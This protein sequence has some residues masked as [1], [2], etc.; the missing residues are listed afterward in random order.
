MS[1]QHA[2]LLVD[3]DVG[4]LESLVYGFREADWRSTACST[5]ETASLLAK[6]S[7]AEIVIVVSRDD[8]AKTQTLVQQLRG[9]GSKR[10]LPILVLGPEELRKTLKESSGADLLPLPVLVRDVLTASK[11][12]VEASVAASQA[13]GSPEIR[14]GAG[15]T[16]IASLLRTMSGLERSGQ[17]HVERNGRPA[18]V[19][20]HEGAVAAAQV[21]QLRGMPA[22]KRVLIWDQEA[23]LHLRPVPR[24]GQVC[25]SGR[26]FVDELDRYQRDL[27]YGLKDIGPLSSVYGC[28]EQRMRQ[29]TGQVPAEVTPVVRLCDGQRSLSDI[30]DESLFPV[31]DTVRILSR[32]AELGI[33]V[34]RAFAE[35]AAPTSAQEQLEAFWQ[36]ARI[37][38]ADSA[39]GA[40]TSSAGSGTF[41]AIPSAASSGVL[42]V[43]PFAPA[44]SELVT[45]LPDV[46][47]A[48]P[49]PPEPA[50]QPRRKTLEIAAPSAASSGSLPAAPAPADASA[51]SPIPNVPVAST[52]TSQTSGTIELHSRKTGSSIRTVPQ[53]R[54]VVIDAVVESVVIDASEA[55]ASV[56]PPPSESAT[57]RITGEIQSA[58]SRRLGKSK[59]AGRV[60]IQLDAAFSDVCTQ[61]PAAT[62]ER[63]VP[64]P[65]VAPISVPVAEQPTPNHPAAPASGRQQ[66]G[67]FSPIEKDFFA[68]EA[69]LYKDDGS[70][71]FADLDAPASRAER[72]GA[73]KKNTR[74]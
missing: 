1:S 60:S 57:V 32:L 38:D 3:A 71:S 37:V 14:F 20:F 48:P 30:L 15:T 65:A 70:E 10:R 46:S 12:L 52:T 42:P 63:Q 55:A 36:T 11:I 21:A 66:S 54:S 28:D 40:S 51:A 8:H 67:H 22:I 29:S 19:S 31:L 53:R 24:R 27:A 4:G 2:A 43:A 49:N 41:A 17:L 7:G 72:N 33:L 45:I 58:P 73:S 39:A 62:E 13:P 6:A 34:R 69:D 64:K 25:R 50:P 23:T 59:P 35:A 9:K 18:E 61:T 16:S 44:Q 5:P 68:R 56:A 26:A 74:K 47:T